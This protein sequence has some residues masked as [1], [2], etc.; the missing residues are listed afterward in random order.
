[1]DEKKVEEDEEI[2]IDFSKIKNI[3][4]RKTDKQETQPKK[5]PE[6]PDDEEISID[7]SK[8]KNIFKSHKEKSKTESKTQDSD[9]ELNIDFSKIT[10]FFKRKIP[11]EKSDTKEKDDELSIDFSGVKRFLNKKLEKTESQEEKVDI[12]E[13]SSSLNLKKLFKSPKEKN[14]IEIKDE[15]EESIQLDI[16]GIISK[17]KG[18]GHIFLPTILLIFAIIL[19]I[20]VRMQ[21]ADVP[22]TDVWAVQSV[23]NYYIQ[24][25]RDSIEQRYPNLPDANKADI[26]NKEYQNLLEEK[27]AE[28]NAQIKEASLFYKSKFQDDNGNLYMPDIDP[29]YWFRYARNI[30]EHGYPGDEIR[31]G[32]QFDNHM[33][34]PQGADIPTTDQF[35][36]YILAYYYRVVRIFNPQIS[37]MNSILYFP[38]L[39]SAL[40][41]IPVFIIARKFGGNLAGIIAGLIFGL[42]TMFV[43]KTLFGH[44]DTDAMVMFFPVFICWLFLLAT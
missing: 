14:E 13:L 7:L 40:S 20:Y 6:K 18:K 25:I 3:F 39:I 9:E 15:H 31:E 32:K 1:M 8:I 42:N 38:L 41:I 17:V 16:K 11:E 37:L 34:A 30:I 43:S 29:Y 22:T 23:S 35:Y 24:Q 33:W 36:P 10:N 26:I 2:S 27:S 19:S 21:N 12:S 28:I 44:A 4:K 5:E